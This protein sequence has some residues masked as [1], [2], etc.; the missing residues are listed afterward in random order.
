MSLG[1]TLRALRNRFGSASTFREA[2]KSRIQLA[3]NAAVQT[4]ESRLLFTTW[5]VEVQPFMT[6][7]NAADLNAGS[8]SLYNPI[9]DPTH[10]G[11]DMTVASGASWMDA[12]QNA[13]TSINV[14]STT[15]GGATTNY[16][17]I[18][19]TRFKETI[20]SDTGHTMP[21]NEPSIAQDS[22][23][24][25]SQKVIAFE[26]GTDDDYN[27]GYFQVYV[28][29]VQTEE[30]GCNCDHNG[31]ESDPGNAGNNGTSNTSGYPVNYFNGAVEMNQTDLSSSGFG[32]NWGVSRSWSNRLGNMSN[33]TL[34]NSMVGNIPQ[35]VN[36]PLTSPN[37]VIQLMLDDRNSVWFET[38]DSGVTYTPDFFSQDQIAA[39]GSGSSSVFTVA[40]ALG[41]VTTFHGFD[42][43]IPAVERGQLSIFT[44]A[45]NNTT[46]ATYNGTGQLTEITRVAGSGGTAVTESFLYAY[47]TSGTNSGKVS[48]VTMRRKVGTGSYST[49]RSVAY[50]YYDGTTAN[51]NAGDLEL[52]QVED[53]SSNVLETDYYRYYAPISVTSLVA[54]TS[55]HVVTATASTTGLSV[56]DEVTVAGAS[57]TSFDGSFLVTGVTGT[58]FTYQ[59]HGSV[60]GTATGTITYVARGYQGGLK[61]FFNSDSYARL[62]AAVVS[63]LSASDSSIAAYATNYFEYNPNFQVSKE[64]AQGAGSDSAGG[65][66]TYT[67]TYTGSL[68]AAGFNS[69]DQKTIETLPDGN[70]N[71]VYSNAYGEQMLKAFVNVATGAQTIDFYEYDGSG[72]QILHANPS[73]V[74][75]YDDTNA[76]LLNSVSGNYQYLRDDTGLIEITDFANSTTATSTTEGDVAGY[77]LDHK[78]EDGELGTAIVQYSQT[79]FS[80][81][82]SSSTFYPIASSTTYGDTAG[83]DVRTT[84]Y[85]YTWYS[86]TVQMQSE[87]IT[88]P[89][90]VA[91]QNGPASSTSDTAQA[92]TTIQY[93]DTY[94]RMIWQRDGDGYL[95]YTQYD[96]ATGAVTK[97]IADVNTADTGDFTGLPS[98]WTTPSGG[99]LELITSNVV[100]SLG[101][102]TEQTDPNGN[103]TYTVFN[104][105]GHEMRVYAGWHQV[106]TNWFTTSPIQV[107][108]HYRPAAGASSGQQTVY[109][110]TLTSSATPAVSG[111]APTGTETIDQTNIQTLT[112]SLTSSGGQMV[113]GDAYFSLSGVTYSQASAKL[114]TSSNDSSSGNYHA[115][116]YGYDN[117]GWQSRVQ[118][119]TGT[120]T[121]TVH[122]GLGRTVSQ[123]VG[124]NDT[125]ASGSWSPTN[126]TSPSNMVDVQ[127]NTYDQR[128]AAP[129][130]PSLSQTGS[131]STNAITYYA[132]VT[133][134]SGSGESLASTES[135]VAVYDGNQLVVNSPTSI[136]GATG[137]NVYASLLLT[138]PTFPSTVF[139]GAATTGGFLQAGKIYR[140]KVTATTPNGETDGSTEQSYT[141]PTGTNTNT[142][143]LNWNAVAGASGYKIYRTAGN[144]ATG[145]EKL[146]AVV[147]SGSTATYSDTTN[148]VL[149]VAVPTTNTTGSG[150]ET[151]QNGAAVSI[152]SDWTQ[153]TTATLN[154]GMLIPVDQVGDSNL[155]QATQ[156]PSSTA[157]ND[158][159]TLNLYDWRDRLIAAKQGALMSSGSPN[160]S[161]ET[162]SQHRLITFNSLDNLGETVGTY[163]YAGDGISLYDFADW[164]T[165]TD[166]SSL[167][168]ESANSYDDQGRVYQSN[169]YSVDPSTGTVGSSLTTNTFYDH[170]GDTIEVSNP[171]GQVNKAQFDGAGRDVKN[172]TS[173]GGVI[174]GATQNWANAGTLASDIVVT[175]TLTTYDSSSNPILTLTRERFDNDPTS[176]SG[177]G[178]LAGPAGGNLA[179]R[180]YYSA[181][182]YDAANRMTDSVNA[183]TNGGVAYSYQTLQPGK[184]VISQATA[185]G[186]TTTLVDT[187]RN[188]ASNYFIGYTLTVTGGTD[189]GQSSTVTAY[190][191]STGT[192]TVASAFSAATMSSS[193]YTLTPGLLTGTASSGTTTT[194]VSSALTQPANMFVGWTLTITAG[195]DAGK[196]AVVT[197]FNASTHTL[198]FSPAFPSAIT[199]SS[200]YA[201]TLPALLTHT[202]YD[203][204]GRAH[205]SVDPRGIVSAT[206]YDLMGR[207]TKAISAWD[208]TS[209]ATPTTSTNQTTTYTYDGDNHEVTQTALMPSGTN[210]QTTAY[211]YGVTSP[212][213]SNLFSN[214]LL[215]KI[216]H[217]D[218]TTGAASASAS[219]DQV[220]AYDALGEV[221]AYLDQNG[222]VHLY[223]FDV[224]G[225][226]TSD[227]LSALGSGVD[228]NVVL[229]EF[230]F[231]TAGRPYQQTTENNSSVVQSQD[232]DHY[233]GYGQLTIE[234]QAFGAAVDDSTTGYVGYNYSQP[235]GA[236]YSR[237]VS[238]TYANGRALDY[239]YGA[240]LQITSITHSGTTATV[241]TSQ[242]LPSGFAVGSQLA[243]SGASPSAY[244]GSFQVLS[245]TD[246]THFTY[247]MAS[248]PGSNAT[249]GNITLDLVPQ[250]PVSALSSTAS[251]GDTTVTVTT[252]LPHG[253]TTGASVTISGAT[254]AEFNGTYTITV[255]SSTAFT[256]TLTGTSITNAGDTGLDITATTNP[257]VS[258]DSA[259]SRITAMSDHGGSSAGVILEGY[260]YLGLD[261]IAIQNRP[262]DSTQLNYVTQSGDANA[263]TDGGDRYEGFD[264][265]GRVIDQNWLSTNGGG[266]L[267]RVQYGYDQDGN[268]LYKNNIVNSSFSEIYHA[269]STL[270][271]DNNKGYDSL[272]RLT[273]F[274]R[275]TLSA[276]GHNSN[277]SAPLDTLA[278]ASAVAN[279]GLDALGNWNTDQTN[280]PVTTAVTAGTASNTPTT[281]WYGEK[282]TTG[283]SAVTVTELG[284][285]FITGNTGSH[286][287][288]IVDAATGTDVSGTLVTVSM[289]GG[290][291]GQY[292]YAALT[293]PVTLLAS[294][295]YY[296]VS[297]ETHSGDQWYGNTTTVTTTSAVTVN[298]WA[299]NTGSW[300]SGTTAGQSYVGVDLQYLVTQSRTANS[301]NEI[302]GISGLTTPTFDNNGNMTK[303]ENG[304]IYTYDAWNNLREVY[305]PTGTT[306]LERRFYDAKGRMTTYSGLSQPFEWFY[307]DTQGQ[308]TEEYHDRTYNQYVWSLGY[309]NQIVLRDRNA[310]LNFTTGNLGI[311]SSALE[312]RLYVQNDGNFN[313]T[314]LVSQAG[315]V[316]KRYVYDPYGQQTILTASFAPGSD[317]G[318]YWGYGFQGGWQTGGYSNVLTFGARLYSPTLGRW[319]QQ[320]PAGYVDGSSLYQFV[321]SDPGVRRDPSGFAEV[322]GPPAPPGDY[323]VG[324]PV[325]D[326]VSQLNAED[327]AE[328]ETALENL[329]QTLTLDPALYEPLEGLQNTETFAPAQEVAIKYAG[330]HIPTWDAAPHQIVVEKCDE[331]EV[332]VSATN[333]WS[334]SDD[335]AGIVFSPDIHGEVVTALNVFGTLTLPGPKGETVDTFTAN[336]VGTT[337]ITFHGIFNITNPLR[338]HIRN[339]LDLPPVKVD[340]VVLPST[341]A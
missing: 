333:P 302:T 103:V 45:N 339:F 17:S 288:K 290:T 106:G 119:P 131:G 213:Y 162:D 268:V 264:R 133:Y 5:I 306:L 169:T 219:N 109:D 209:T 8:L 93:F 151:L 172:S 117:R 326:Y 95:A 205:D 217:P 216:E 166:S 315:V 232:E 259:I 227:Y 65:L 274:G 28:E 263:L 286:Q 199:S 185:T 239:V 189:A 153:P 59:G 144:G 253:L 56:G 187:T 97:Q 230:N 160:P 84:I 168:A 102:T 184:N 218:L 254:Q 170:R 29:P 234:Y 191:N 183:G 320:D 207:T 292:M 51:G 77:L 114:G 221:N 69:W 202:D 54:N 325:S 319:I 72:R 298:G 330:S 90:I 261:T 3:A 328:R 296:L 31:P 313:I 173:D 193:V 334:N 175:Q 129:G 182:Y 287:I 64:I 195:T 220:Y 188:E 249:G 247:T 323:G 139:T 38:S 260:T 215:L 33:G 327:P 180:D 312:E 27:D 178:D 148:P 284:R 22:G 34:G 338:H 1:V 276:S 204:A 228:S 141:V 50:T 118:A 99:G 83:T 16:T 58:T 186:T 94:G 20:A 208:G 40:D 301:Q 35:L 291:N 250:V 79:Y 85:A 311:A 314:S 91:A 66:G 10:Q 9:V 248:T 112:R 252:A 317:G 149:G 295:S 147:T 310:D 44:D 165:S 7:G 104:D 267:D 87:T 244:D 68:N 266:T 110:E 210:N 74:S 53:S 226:T 277:S 203:A 37:G 152:G 246:S 233:N 308:V 19:D 73:A 121:R 309:V 14:A 18:T 231:D 256:Y 243:I 283:S 125:P 57:P 177:E 89:P 331:F 340:V 229:H 281:G 335:L 92:D 132:K 272:N 307:Y 43:A 143:T 107:T 100:D 265:F 2:K 214:D 70:Q 192:F 321:K 163:T 318:T 26:D 297:N 116:L 176:S 211:I 251:G 258:L 167:Q 61:Y 96:A 161:G 304:Q 236:N 12:V 157:S 294:H 280:T 271:G 154:Y 67:F 123:W 255:T 212:S 262:E 60:S 76:D 32:T 293:S 245:V 270:T 201:L 285:I 324:Y 299:A 241:T 113:E 145:T 21:S 289:T 174:N 130:A 300:T 78:V 329:L 122:D 11:F 235:S 138:A 81:S 128:Q 224:L 142:I 6:Q 135:S 137:Y 47:L 171:G 36:W 332:Q 275:G 303:D 155:T 190:N 269:N 278:S 225:R 23:L 25:G 75:G 115:T 39:S 237:L 181:A 196:S 82:G 223:S 13:V 42:V 48:T 179:S 63:P 322:Q 146:L 120:I 197:G 150:T 305:D 341:K 257:F 140:Y 49:V 159:T 126:N 124:T 71:I 30:G 240:Q 62:A 52:A 55:T 238:M 282:F 86:G 156:H 46:N 206:Y 105:P 337:T 15:P 273:G 127:D 222:S 4:L 134:V 88:Q 164:S 80:R 24:P 242:P 316:Q 194:L 108:R 98:G 136:A 111:A 158:R 336:E 41:Q 279:W 198:T 101:R 200:V